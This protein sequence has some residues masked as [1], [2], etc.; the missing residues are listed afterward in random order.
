MMLFWLRQHWL[1]LS[2]TALIIGVPFYY[3]V[4][5][6]YFTKQYEARCLQEAGLKVFEKL[7]P[8][9]VFIE[10]NGCIEYFCMKAL[11][12][13]K[14]IPFVG[15][16]FVL[17]TEVT[18]DA[19]GRKKTTEY[20][21]PMRLHIY[22]KNNDIC[23]GADFSAGAGVRATLSKDQINGY[24]SFWRKFN[25]GDKCL[26]IEKRESIQALY[27]IEPSFAENVPPHILFSG[28][29]IFATADN[30]KIAELTYM[31]FRSKRFIDALQ[32]AL[33]GGGPKYSCNI[34][35]RYRGIGFLKA[36]Y[37]SK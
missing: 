8:G 33:E 28:Q 25:P 23:K 18:K 34:S 21:F 27:R 19:Q 15:S 9:G 13:F 32:A 6:I 5:E 26:Y 12:H 11:L 37:R 31:D 1:K 30:R 3:V 16:N 14:E 24:K 10:G 4:R 20:Y 22:D 36:V 29:R 7:R 17:R 35:P 2:V